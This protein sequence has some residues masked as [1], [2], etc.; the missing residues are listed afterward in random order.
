MREQSVETVH[1]LEVSVGSEQS[2]HRKNRKQLEES[3]LS[4]II[5]S[6]VF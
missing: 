6:N 2:K 3:R 5:S 1:K 4:W